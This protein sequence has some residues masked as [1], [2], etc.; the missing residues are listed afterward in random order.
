MRKGR[1]KTKIHGFQTTFLFPTR[2]II[3]GT[4][5][6]QAFRKARTEYSDDF[7]PTSI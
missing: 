5:S 6:W 3:P 4:K 1:L 7:Q 2:Q